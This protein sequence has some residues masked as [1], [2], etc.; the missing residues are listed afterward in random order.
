[1]R[2][3]HGL[4]PAVFCA[5]VTTSSPA[6]S[7]DAQ[8]AGIR[9]VSGELIDKLDSKT[10]KVDDRVVIKIRSA[11][12]MPDS[13]DIPKGSKLI[14]RVTGVKPARSNDANSQ[15]ALA[16]DRVELKNGQ[17]LSVRGELQS[18]TPAGSESSGPA[19]AMAAASTSSPAGREPGDMY[20][21]TPSVAPSQIPNQTQAAN[22]GSV[23][24]SNAAS[25]AGTVVAHSGDLTIRTTSIPGLLLANHDA[26]SSATQASSILLATRRDVHLESGTHVV[27][28]LESVTLTPAA[29]N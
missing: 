8:P 9:A 6:Q 15:I 20:G 29:S 14:G 12:H 26:P 23:A 11:M 17:T 19:D 16:F 13:T 18:I 5:L 28:G 22:G 24:G 3:V 27:V 25:N 2:A 10:A 4:L 7:P 21:S 1:M